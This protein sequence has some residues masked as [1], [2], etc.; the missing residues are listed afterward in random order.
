MKRVSHFES[1]FSVVKESAEG[2]LIYA[3]SRAEEQS[4]T[5]KPFN[6]GVLKNM[7]EQFRSFK[8]GEESRASMS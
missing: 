2:L 6:F 3:T 1:Q 4:T 5:E 8:L 7:I